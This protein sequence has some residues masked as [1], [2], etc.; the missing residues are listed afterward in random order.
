MKIT[1]EQLEA[2]RIVAS[3]LNR[4]DKY[5]YLRED[6]KGRYIEYAFIDGAPENN[7]CLS[8]YDKLQPNALKRNGHNIKD[9]YIKPVD[10]IY[11]LSMFSC[12]N[13]NEK[14]DQCCKPGCPKRGCYC[15][16]TWTFDE[17]V[18]CACWVLSEIYPDQKIVS[19]S[20]NQVCELI[21][22]KTI[23]PYQQ[24]C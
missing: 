13:E 3:Y 19:L 8:W 16:D 7:R 20:M 24:K 18:K 2:L 22:N 11:E 14:G 9:W 5:V 1:A 17:P 10:E 15:T 4:L 21:A 12:G 6:E 23:T